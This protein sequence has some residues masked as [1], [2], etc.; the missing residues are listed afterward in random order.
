MA[1]VFI[2]YTSAD[3]DWAKWLHDECVALGH[4]PHIHEF[5]IKGSADIFAWM[6]KRH[7]AADHVLCVMSDDYLKAP[8]STL[9][10]NAAHWQAAAKRP[11][12][13]LFVVVKPCTL[14]TLSDHMR[15]VELH[16]VPED[17]ARERFRIFMEGEK[18]EAF[19]PFPGRAAALHNITVA[20]PTHFMGRDDALADIDAALKRYAGRVAITALHGLRGVGKSTLARVYAERH[21]HNYRATWWI[22]AQSAD[23][24][25]TDLVGLGV[26]LQWVPPDL[27]ESDALPRVMERLA[28][29]GEGVLLIYDNAMDEKSLRPFLPKGGSARIII[30]SNAHAWRALAE[31]VEIRLWPKET[32]G[33]YLVART[34]REAEREAAEALSHALGGLPLAHEQAAAFCEEMEIGL[35]DYLRRFEAQPAEFLDD[36]AHAPGDYHDGLTVAKTFALAIEAAGRR[37]PL[38]EPL[39]VLCALLA[40]EPV[41]LFL[42]EDAGEYFGEALPELLAGNALEKAVAA[43]RSFAL[44]ERADHE[45]D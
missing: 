25:R 28:A 17:A 2:S 33:N 6:E 8:Y 29:E 22:R 36:A 32:G 5:E 20:T 15:R 14:P 1:D 37:H 40:P 42:F 43:L 18:P 38:A 4:T 41:P 27:D 35:G 44:I 21:R 34:G 7:N 11:G 3:R 16:G 24:L 26:R 12:F 39:I 23:G 10:R 19:T 45:R 30:T 31:P 9:E 13:V